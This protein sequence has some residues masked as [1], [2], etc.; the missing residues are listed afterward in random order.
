MTTPQVDKMWHE[1]WETGDTE[2]HFNAIHPILKRQ[3]DWLLN[4]KK[5]AKIFF[6]FCGKAV[7][8][9]WLYDQGH[10]IVGVEGVELPVQEFFNE[11]QLEYTAECT[12]KG[13]FK[14]YTSKDGRLQLLVG[15][16]YD[17]TPEQGNFDAVW[18][19]GAMEAVQREEWVPYVKK[20]TSLVKPEARLLVETPYRTDNKGPP[21]FIPVDKMAELYGDKYDVKEADRYNPFPKDSPHPFLSDFISY[22]V[23]RKTS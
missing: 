10:V 5:R 3:L 14:Y 8:M 19:R 22:S 2:F 20:M 1:G 16:Y 15:N 23:E 13:V 7:D 12:Q 11:S 9:K 18:D 17:M 6:P 4:D 21:F